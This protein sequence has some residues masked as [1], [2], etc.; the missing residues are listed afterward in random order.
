LLGRLRGW[1][2]RQF[3]RRA[4][5][6]ETYGESLATGWFALWAIFHGLEV[7]RQDVF[8]DLGS[9]TGRVLFMAA[10]RPFRRVVGIESDVRLSEIARANLERN[11]RRLRCQEFEVLTMDIRE[12]EPHHDVS[13]VYLYVAYDY[14]PEIP[15]GVVESLR[16]SITRSP[17]RVRLILPDSVPEE[18]E[19]SLDGWRL[20]PL[21]DRVARPLRGRLPERS[22]VATLDRS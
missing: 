11:R 3:E 12:W 10:R 7:S 9:G 20:E 21:R 8:V 14:A 2:G 22:R 17:R 4:L 5:G 15:Q 6:V 1:T 16:S 18:L 13:V 19:R